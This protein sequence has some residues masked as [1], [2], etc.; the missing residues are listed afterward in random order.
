MQLYQSIT[1][2]NKIFLKRSL[3]ELIM[4][5]YDF[6]GDGKIS[7]K[8]GGMIWNLILIFEE[9]RATLSQELNEVIVEQFD[10]DG[11]GVVAGDELF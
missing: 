9:E 2:I 5:H 6:D 10:V 11:D 8:E 3:E 7:M 4:E 1:G